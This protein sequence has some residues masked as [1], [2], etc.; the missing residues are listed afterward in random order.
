MRILKI[1]APAALFILQLVATP[2]A[3]AAT[4]CPTAS[5]VPSNGRT[6]ANVGLDSN[7]PI[8]NGLEYAVMCDDSKTH[9]RTCRSDVRCSN[10]ASDPY[11]IGNAAWGNNSNNSQTNTQGNNSQSSGN[12]Y[13][14]YRGKK[15]HCTEWDYKNER[16]CK[17]GKFNEDCWGNCS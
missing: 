17:N 14:V 10:Q 16:P 3:L 5:W 1:I 7:R 12:D 4:D 11:D 8:C 9:I 6:C 15:F 2:N 13:E